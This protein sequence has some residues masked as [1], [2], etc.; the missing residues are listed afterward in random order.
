MGDSL[1]E[2]ALK[3][4]HMKSL[5]KFVFENGRQ[6]ALIAFACLFAACT[7]SSEDSGGSPPPPPPATAPVA[8]AGV[9]QTVQELTL[10]NLAGSATDVN[11]DPI[12]YSWAQT[13][14]IAVT[15]NTPDSA[16]ASFTAP[17]VVIGSPQV[18]TFELTASDPGLLSSSDTVNITVQETA[19]PVTI[20]GILT[21]EFPPPNNNCRGLDFGNIQPRPIRRA[22]VQLLDASGTNLLGT[23]VAG[24][25]GA[26]SFAVDPSTDY[27]IRV[28][29]ELKNPSWDVEVRNNVDTSGSPP[30]LENR[31][32][33]VMDQAF[34][35]GAS[36]NPNMDLTAT[37]GWGVNSYT[38]PRV[39]APFA[40]LDSIYSAI[41]FVVAE[42]AGAVFPPLD[43]FWSPDNKQASPT[44]VDAGDLPTSFY[45]GQSQLFLLG[46]DGV[47]TEEFDDHVITHEWSH[48]FEDNFSRSDSIGG[49]HFI[50]RDLLDK[51]VAFGEGF[52]DAMSAMTLGDPLYCDTSGFG[53]Q[54]GFGVNM[55]SSN[56]LNDGWFDEV[57]VFEIIY[58]LWDT[59]N[60][61]VDNSS[62]GFGPIYDVMT[63]PQVTAPSFTSIFSFA[64]YLKQ[65]NP[66]QAAFIDA[67]LTDHNIVANGIDIFG[68]SE[69]NDGPG[70]PD[71]V[72]PIYTDIT[73]GVTT[74]ICVNSQFD[75]D[76]D[77]NKVSEH[78][79]LR[80]NLASNTRVTFEMTANPAP[81]QPSAGFDCSADP[82]D[83]ENSEHSDPDFLVWNNGQLFWIGFECDPNTEMSTTDGFLAAGNYVIDIND[84]RHEDEDSPAVYPDQVCFDFT[85]N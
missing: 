60:D 77:G 11:N 21:Y 82:D 30:P 81:S 40:I 68:D 44:D 6:M 19:V 61:G 46:L 5:G 78:R 75:D 52:A 3:D 1:W 83:P 34:N 37:T 24:A 72:M 47:D 25:N 35:S 62:I 79:Y 4:R 53:N 71:D 38:N 65:Q 85:A 13:G 59:N 41:Q 22:T 14:G 58:D 55:E 7:S 74:N 15:I 73:L 29:A 39:A 84:F 80:L 23:V 43:A 49:S 8:N 12:T 69:T 50:G 64:T 32:I 20:S 27:I 63:G 45:N 18:L 36:S 54:N 16:A 57:S 42:D 48:Y 26:Y 76:R 2:M 67:L 10:V 9:D 17:D 56:S 33:Y 31:P 66:G 70:T 28:R 51:R